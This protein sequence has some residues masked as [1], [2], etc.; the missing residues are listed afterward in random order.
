[1]KQ[2]IFVLL[3]AVLVLLLA[4]SLFGCEKQGSENN[5]QTNED[6][7]NV[8]VEKETT[9]YSGMSKEEI[10]TEFMKAWENDDIVVMDELS[11][12]SESFTNSQDFSNYGYHGMFCWGNV[13]FPSGD[14][15]ICDHGCENFSHAVNDLEI[16]QSDNTDYGCA[17]EELQSLHPEYEN[18]YV[19]SFTMDENSIIRHLEKCI[20]GWKE[21]TLLSDDVFARDGVYG[22]GI[23]F[24][25]FFDSEKGHWIIKE[26]KHALN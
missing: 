22:G 23:I 12:F 16:R 2:R 18:I 24:E 8:I 21:G 3:T 7:E 13:S 17:P 4:L 11:D 10:I 6:P 9:D 5:Q 14:Y 25:M 19:V 26:E 15:L 20:F 1:M